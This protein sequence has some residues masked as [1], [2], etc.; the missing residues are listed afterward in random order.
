MKYAEHERE[1]IGQQIY[2]GEMTCKQASEVYEV[3]LQSAKRYLKLYRDK[4]GLPPKRKKAEERIFQRHTASTANTFED[5]ENM[6][7]EELIQ[8][9]IRAKINEERAKKGYA[10]KGVGAQKEYI[11]LGSK[12]TKS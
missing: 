2:N 10:V 1:D 12:N 7:K 4:Y 9:I 8:E 6:S 5:Y 11:H 3:A